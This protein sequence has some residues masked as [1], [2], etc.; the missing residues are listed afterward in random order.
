[1]QPGEVISVN[2]GYYDTHAA[3][4]A[5]RT[6]GLDISHLYEPFLS[7]LPMPADILDAGCGTGRD[8]A[9]FVRLGHRVTA[10]DASA[11]MVAL[12]STSGAT[13]L[14]QTLQEIAFEQC[15]DGIWA[16]AALLHVPREEIARVLRNLERALKPGGVLYVSLKEG[17]GEELTKEGRY[18]VYYE[19]PEFRGLLEQTHNLRIER[20]WETSDPSQTPP[21][22]WLNFLASRG[23][24]CV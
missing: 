8:S 4:F 24:R 1:M 17:K 14:Q 21:T 20:A 2:V 22:R 7:R 23:E 10:T 6:A 11:A 13:V 5:E 15:F 3:E 19:E 18:F 16:C 12:A 9:A